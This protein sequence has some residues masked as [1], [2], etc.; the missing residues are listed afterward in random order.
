MNLPFLSLLLVLSLYRKKPMVSVKTALTS[1][2]SCVNTF[3]VINLRHRGSFFSFYKTRKDFHAVSVLPLDSYDHHI[4]SVEEM[5]DW[6]GRLRYGLEQKVTAPSPAV[7]PWWS[8]RTTHQV[9]RDLTLDRDASFECDLCG[10]RRG[11]RGYP[12]KQ[13]T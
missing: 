2:N 11:L 7:P 6:E 5:C 9:C 8:R 3:K 4:F 1:R 10:A 13:Y 12:G